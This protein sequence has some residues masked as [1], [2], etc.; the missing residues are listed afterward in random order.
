MK[1]SII[2]FIN[3]VT[4]ALLRDDLSE[5]ILCATRRIFVQDAVYLG[6]FNICEQKRQR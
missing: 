4:F 6:S 5:G 1:K 3:G 2:I